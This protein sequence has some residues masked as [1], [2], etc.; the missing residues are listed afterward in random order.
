M[1]VRTT[2]DLVFETERRLTLVEWSPR[3]S[4]ALLRSDPADV[5]AGR[6]ELR[7][8]GAAAVC[9]RE[10]LDGLRITLTRAVP[11]VVTATLG[12]GLR[13][14]EHLYTLTSGT[15]TGWIVADGAHGLQHDLD[16]YEA[17]SFASRASGS[18]SLFSHGS[19]G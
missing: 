3:A 14:G 4:G 7:F 9:L 17:L 13:T 1:T 19:A 2:G 5:S 10:M 12:R 16:Q 18:R 15:V 6:I 11:D 8:T